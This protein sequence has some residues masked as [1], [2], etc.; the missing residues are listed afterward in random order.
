MLQIGKTKHDEASIKS[1][2][3]KRNTMRHRSREKED[4]VDYGSGETLLKERLPVHFLCSSRRNS[5]T[6]KLPRFAFVEINFGDGTTGETS[7]K[8]FPEK[9]T[10]ADELEALPAETYCMWRPKADCGSLPAMTKIKKSSSTGSGSKRWGIRYLLWR[11]K[12]DGKEPVVLLTPKKQKR[13][14]NENCIDIY[15][16]AQLS[17][18]NILGLKEQA[19]G[20]ISL[21]ILKSLICVGEGDLKRDDQNLKRNGAVVARVREKDE[22]GNGV[23]EY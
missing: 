18:R 5:L 22:K 1:R 7:V 17:K 13:V 20:G 23:F 4:G 6:R 3:E 14:P 12:S 19:E 21:Q 2:S 16:Q 8:N 10:E 11:S 15:T 9:A